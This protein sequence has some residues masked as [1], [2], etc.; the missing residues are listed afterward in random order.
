VAR[1]Q[2]GAG[3]AAIALGGPFL[4]MLAYMFVRAEFFPHPGHE[5]AK[6]S[7]WPETCFALVLAVFV[8]LAWRRVDAGQ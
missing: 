1:A 2:T 6:F 8:L 5:L 3:G 4:A 7:E